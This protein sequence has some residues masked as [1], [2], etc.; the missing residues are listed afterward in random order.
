[1]LMTPL[2]DFVGCCGFLPVAKN[3]MKFKKHI[4]LF[5]SFIHKSKRQYVRRA[6]YVVY[7]SYFSRTLKKYLKMDAAKA[8]KV[9]YHEFAFQFSIRPRLRLSFWAVAALLLILVSTIRLSRLVSENKQAVIVNGQ[10]VMVA[11]S[12]S[13]QV[14]PLVEI[15]SVV[16]PKLSPFAYINPVDDGIVSQ[17]FSTYHHA[18]DIATALGTDIRPIG[19]GVVEFAGFVSDGKGNIVVVD[20]GDGLKTIYAHM[21]KIEVGVGNSVDSKTTLGSVGLTGRTTG[22]HLHLEV[23]DRGVPINPASVLP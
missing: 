16:E 11:E 9:A 19:S 12:N 13:G 6:K 1:M 8:V 14:E 3:F 10:A 15:S 22:P 20:H 23:Y 4:R 5:R 17:G 2:F 7:R 21:N 18:V